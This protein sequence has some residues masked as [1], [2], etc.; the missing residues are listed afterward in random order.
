MSETAVEKIRNRYADFF[1]TF[2]ER[3]DFQRV[4]EIVDNA[5]N[6]AVSDDV[7]V[8]GKLIVLS[9]AERAVDAFADFYR[10]ILPPTIVN[11]LSEDLKWVLNKARETATV[12]WLEG[13][14]K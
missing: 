3:T 9:D 2:A 13:Q 5:T 7:A 8:I 6:T 12:L 10:R 4:L 11:N 1:T 14:R